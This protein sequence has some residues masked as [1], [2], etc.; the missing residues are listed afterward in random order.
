MSPWEET[1]GSTIFVAILPI[2]GVANWQ[3]ESAG[4]DPVRRRPAVNLFAVR[5]ISFKEP[6][7]VDPSGFVRIRWLET[8]VSVV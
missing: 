3:S 6:V 2:R 7:V 1:S 8:I 5:L 4:S